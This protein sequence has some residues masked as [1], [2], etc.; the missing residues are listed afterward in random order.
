M[1]TYLLISLEIEYA[2]WFK[3]WAIPSLFCLHF[4][5]FNSLGLF[6]TPFNCHFSNAY[7]SFC[8][9]MPFN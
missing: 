2:F 5:L 8:F 6:K 3:K 7:L 4:R 1:I 9:E